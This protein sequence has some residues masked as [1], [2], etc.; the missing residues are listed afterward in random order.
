M[1]PADEEFKPTVD[2]APDPAPGGPDAVEHDEDDFPV[3]TP[4]QPRSAQLKEEQVPDE[5]EQPD[6]GKQEG[7][8]SDP[9]SLAKGEA[10]D[11]PPA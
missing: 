5:I 3:V 10:G 8:E 9:E 2:P 11:E 6:E 1:S 7:D 4:D